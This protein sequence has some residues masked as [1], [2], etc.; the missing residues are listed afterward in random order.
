MT[1][2]LSE[3]DKA[4]I[5]A[6]F[7]E[8]IEKVA[9]AHAADIQEAYA[10]GF[11][12]LAAEVAEAKDEEDKKEKEGSKED[13]DED[14]KEKMDEESEKKAAELGAFIERGFFDGLRKLGA[15]RHN[16]EAY[17]LE[18]FI[19][20]KVA[21]ESGKKETHYVRRALLGNPLSSAIEAPMGRKMEAYGQAAGHTYGNAMVGGVAGGAAGAAV[22]GAAGA[23]GSKYLGRALL[24]PSQARTM[25][26]HK[27][28]KGALAGAALGAGLGLLGG[29]LHGEF[30]Q[31]GTEIHQE[32][33][34][35]K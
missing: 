12:K 10:Y 4:L 2:Q 17:Y 25:M 16:N 13:K 31:R 35:K 11:A 32:A 29:A 27:S 28:G 6:D 24:H 7:G 26:A 1:I 34:N 15:E 19:T 21:E 5:N 33:A 9:A 22:G 30:G 20:A 23:A 8:E 3:Q 18:P 14:K